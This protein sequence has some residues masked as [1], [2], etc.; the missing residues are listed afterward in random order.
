MAK[1]KIYIDL[2][3]GGSDPGAVAN[4]LEEANVVLEI[5]KYMKDMFA[6]YENAEVKFSRLSDKTLSL[7]Q[8][9]NEANDWGAF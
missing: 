8:R 4:G 2:G 3:H 7:S 1:K 6:N 9:T 5:G